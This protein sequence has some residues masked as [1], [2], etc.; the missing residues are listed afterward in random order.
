MQ[1]VLIATL[2]RLYCVL[3]DFIC[4]LTPW[5]KTSY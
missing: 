3:G 2:S 1:V 5:Y 4:P